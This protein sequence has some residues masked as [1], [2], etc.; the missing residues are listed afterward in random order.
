M[1]ILLLLIDRF[2]ESMFLVRGVPRDNVIHGVPRIDRAHFDRVANSN[3]NLVSTRQTIIR[4]NLYFES[5]YIIIVIFQSDV[6][7]EL[8]SQ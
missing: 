4:T 7:G 3:V 8:H 6:L 2:A 5:N 1:A